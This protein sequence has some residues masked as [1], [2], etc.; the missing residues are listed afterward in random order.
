MLP[1]IAH[2]PLAA[3]SGGALTAVQSA[4]VLNSGTFTI[5]SGANRLLV[6]EI[7]GMCSSASN[8][9]AAQAPTMSAL[10]FA[11][12][13]V[14]ILG[15]EYN[16]NDR[17][18]SGMGYLINPPSG[19]GVLNATANPPGQSS[20]SFILTEYAGANQ[21]V[22]MAIIGQGNSAA[23]ALTSVSP[24]GNVTTAGSIMHSMITLGRRNDLPSSL[25]TVDAGS[26][27]TVAGSTGSGNF[28]DHDYAGA[29]KPVA[30]P[31]AAAT[32]YSWTGAVRLTWMAAEV[33]SA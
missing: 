14:T 26:S 11:G 19:T 8:N 16:A 24:G 31:G 30:A 3:G 2:K 25:A 7:H 27:L 4:R 33:K 32:T 22:P 23:T 10:T 20:L 13:P 5:G 12:Q 17:S 1:F 9:S 18:W 29:T 6:V 28:S 21:T 15:Y